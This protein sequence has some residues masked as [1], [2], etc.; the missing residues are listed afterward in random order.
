MRVGDREASL[1]PNELTDE[2][3]PPRQLERRWKH[4]GDPRLLSRWDQLIGE[5][6]LPR[7][8]K[9]RILS[10]GM[11]AWVEWSEYAQKYRITANAC[12][13][14]YCPLC[15]HR[16][17]RT[18]HDRLK[19]AVDAI[20]KGRAKLI[21]LTQRSTT[22]PLTTQLVNLWQAFRRLRE[23]KVWKNNV[24]GSVTVLEVTYNE[25]TNQWHPH[26]HSICS[27]RF[28]PQKVLAREW[29]HSSR[30]SMIV[31]VRAVKNTEKTAQYL[32]SY[33][34][35]MPQMSTTDG[36]NPWTELLDS[37]RG[38]RLIR[39]H[40]TLRAVQ[41]TAPVD[42][43]Y[44]CDWKRVKP[45]LILIDDALHGSHSATTILR[46]IQRQRDP[47]SGERLGPRRLLTG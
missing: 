22:A 7:K 46:A 21:T 12:K 19:N 38:N 39:F 9:E 20:P 43:D 36:I 45:L 24:R 34:T 23:R 6:D 17:T 1:D 33:L 2:K 8:T 11:N 5:T 47:P 37:T 16:W 41:K 3:V 14:R 28:I 40:G 15:R 13:H 44:P 29:L 30:G 26:L 42:D 35:K 31:D 27:A 10:C 18:T 25:E 32:T 4:Y